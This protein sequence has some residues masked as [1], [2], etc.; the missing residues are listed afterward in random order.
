MCS[1]HCG[2]VI[3]L[4]CEFMNEINEKTVPAESRKIR[5]LV[6]IA[7]YGLK[8]MELL[9]QLILGYQ[10]LDMDVDVVVISN[11]PKELVMGVT[12]FVGLPSKNP[13]SLP[14]AHKPI[15]ARNVEQYD[16]FAYSEDDIG[17][18]KENIQAFLSATPHLAENEIAGFLRYEVDDSGSLSLPE[19]HGRY[20]WKPESVKQRGDYTI[21]EFSNEHAAFY[22]L[23]QDQ[24]KKAIASGGFL[25]QPYE[26]RYDMLCTAAT[27]PY[28]SCGFHKVI[29]IS[30]VEDFL[31][32]HLSN[33]YTG[34]FGI[35]LPSVKEQIQTQ[36]DIASG[37]HPASKLCHSES[38]MM[39]GEWSKNYYELP[40]EELLA[41]VPTNAKTIL[42]IGC[43]WGATESKLMER[44]ATITAMPLDSIIG[45]TAAHL[46]IDVVYGA[47]D[48][49][50]DQLEDRTFDCVIITGLLHLLP[51]PQLVV[52]QCAYLV[53]QGG[54]FV[55]SG[56]NFGSARVLAKR[57]LSLRDYQKLR[58]FDESGINI[59]SP[60]SLKGCLKNLGLNIT[61]VRWLNGTSKSYVKRKIRS[62]IAESW[63]LQA[64][65]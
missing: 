29:C 20:Y 54:S 52:K 41:L 57:L 55:I 48:E 62:L 59:V 35:S 34:Q 65:R 43:G 8:N 7:S 5:L 50:F 27:D 6:V 18:T 10:S 19:V 46:G 47:L 26:G 13:W 15:F 12:V 2:E 9:K 56:P 22:L 30:A 38:R 16:L 31:I 37:I 60:I 45:V 63:V 58:N 11:E 4:V 14:F 28:T 40:N 32:H 3:F 42:S 44:G 51:N 64:R 53:C 36:L 39:Q 23:T 61:A 1:C 21:A 24:L 17:V 49:C 25:R 33:R